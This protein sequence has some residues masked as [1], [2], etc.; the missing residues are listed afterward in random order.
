[1]WARQLSEV[2]QLAGAQ[3]GAELTSE[4]SLVGALMR[5][6]KQI[7]DEPVCDLANRLQ[8]SKLI[9]NIMR[10]AHSALGKARRDLTSMC[11]SSTS[12]KPA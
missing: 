1:M 4:F 7:D 2:G 12:A 11:S 5:Q 6:R 10:G 3:V 9:E 8:H